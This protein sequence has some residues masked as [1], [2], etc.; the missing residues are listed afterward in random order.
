LIKLVLCIANPAVAKSLRCGLL[1]MLTELKMV[2]SEELHQELT[3]QFVRFYRQKFLKWQCI[4]SKLL[5]C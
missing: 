2:L 4:G 3:K 5:C 1:K